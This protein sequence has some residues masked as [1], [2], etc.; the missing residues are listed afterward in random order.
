MYKCKTCQQITCY[1]AA[2]NKSIEVL[3]QS[4][5]FRCCFCKGLSP[6]TT[7]ETRHS[8]YNQNSIIQNLF[9][10]SSLTNFYGLLNPK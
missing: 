7:R 1:C 9:P 10:T 8:N 3:L 4:Q 5:F 6:V 2:C